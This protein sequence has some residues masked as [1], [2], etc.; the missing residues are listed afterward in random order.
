MQ[1]GT[2]VPGPGYHILFS[3]AGEEF[4]FNEDSGTWQL[5]EFSQP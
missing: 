4:R 5:G 1:E 3:L 2:Y